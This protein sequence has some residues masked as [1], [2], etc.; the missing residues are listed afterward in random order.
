MVDGGVSDSTIDQN[1]IDGSR[2]IGIELRDGPSRIEIKRNTI[3]ASNKQNI[4]IK[5]ATSPV[6]EQNT[7]GGKTREAIRLTDTTGAR[8]RGN[9]IATEGVLLRGAS[10]GNEFRDNDLEDMGFEFEGVEERSGPW[11]FPEYNRIQGGE[12][13]NARRCFIFK[14]ASF[15]T[16]MVSRSTSVPAGRPRTRRWTDT[17]PPGT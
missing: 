2:D 4:D 11:R 5:L 10:T 17:F 9:R 13:L 6:V 12:I 8:I 15:N 1:A 16:S 3:F 7:L 14:G